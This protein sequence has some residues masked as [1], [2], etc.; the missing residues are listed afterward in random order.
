M[1]KGVWAGRWRGKLEE[2]DARA[3][4]EERGLVGVERGFSE[5]FSKIF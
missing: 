3:N 2:K 1:K 4:V 5:D